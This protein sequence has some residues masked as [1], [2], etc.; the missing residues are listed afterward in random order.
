MLNVTMTMF[1]IHRQQRIRRWRT[2]TTKIKPN[3]T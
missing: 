2:E 3:V 1:I